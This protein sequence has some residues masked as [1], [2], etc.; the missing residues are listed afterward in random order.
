M[1][2]TEDVF[3]SFLLCPTKA[4]LLSQGQ[5]GTKSEYETYFTGVDKEYC[6][7]A[8]QGH[9][10]VD[11][12]LE[13]IGGN[14]GEREGALC[15]TTL[16]CG[17]MTAVRVI[18][19]VKG[20]SALGSFHYV[21][22]M[23]SANRSISKEERM[24]L[25]YQGLVLEGVQSRR[26]E[27]GR[28]IH[29]DSFIKVR[30]GDQIEKARKAVVSIKKMEVNPPSLMLNRHCHI[31]EFVSSCRVKAIE[32]D[33]LSLLA[34]IPSKEIETQ[35]KKGIFTVT[36]YS[37]TFRPRKK[38][39][40]VYPYNLKA[41]ALREK[42]THLYGTPALPAAGVQIYL[43]VEGDPDRDF[44]YLIG[45]VIVENG[46][47]KRHSFWAD[48]E[49]EEGAACL[50]F[51]NCIRSYGDYKP[52][53]Y[54][55]Y[56][57][58]FQQKVKSYA[59]DP[60]D[61]LIIE[62]MIAN[63]VNVLSIVYKHVF[64]PTYSNGLKDIGTYLGFKWTSEDASGINSLVWRAQFEETKDDN[65]KRRLIEYNL[66][67]CLALKRVVQFVGQIIKDVVGGGLS[68]D[69]FIQADALK[70][71]SINRWGRVDFVIKD[72]KRINDCAY[73][74]YQREKVFIRTD[75]RLKKANKR[76]IKKCYHRINKKIFIK[77]LKK[78]P[79]CRGRMY[80]NADC[81][82]TVFD[83]KFT[84][85]GVHRVL[86]SYCT[87][88]M[89]CSR[90]TKTMAMPDE[91]KVINR[92]GH[93]LVSFVVYQ[94]VEWHMPYDRTERMLFDLFGFSTRSMG[95]RL[96][97]MGV[98]YYRSTSQ[99]ILKRIL[100]GKFIHIDETKINVGKVSGYVWVFSNMEDVYF[101]YTT[102]RE[103]DF[104][105]EML[106]DFKGVIISDF[107]GAYCYPEW[108]QQKCLVHLIRDLNDDMRSAP[109]DEEYKKITEDFTM[110]LRK[111]IDT[112]DKYGLKRRH[113]AKHKKEVS[114]FFLNMVRG[115]FHSELAQKYQ[116]R[117]LKNEN[118]LFTFLDYDGVPWNNNNAEHAIKHFAVYRGGIE[119]FGGQTKEE[120][121]KS[122][123][124]LLSIFQTC[125]YRGINFLKFLV[126][127]ETDIDRFS[128]SR[129][130]RCPEIKL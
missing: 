126:S 91:Y 18:E 25:A 78:C 84:G 38:F 79:F 29:G 122:H 57:T 32:K 94:S 30:I 86:T 81:A 20:G 95:K 73:F 110:L 66:D 51:V 47:E 72:M 127:K 96:K 27:F 7:N 129:S 1:N 130:R 14:S 54:G 103:D 65:L 52:Y 44:Y 87:S 41:L 118:T 106:A 37:Y 117:F 28:V 11:G 120:G 111:V 55:S 64:F 22:V 77:V 108:I 48:N 112:V 99:Q 75:K 21:P 63:A 85:S 97:E 40:K 102:T 8:L 42:K 4:Y 121:I 68:R 35:N 60:D 61:V 10:V 5:V 12:S 74:D 89:R 45:A 114:K 90:C 24:G 15:Q 109:F 123:L 53:H 92:Y 62:K 23:F 39:R 83:L 70:A 128:Q 107:Y 19:R 58:K 71:K 6:T 80:I 113:L 88:Q 46:I 13:E 56:E 67:D 116:K 50:A 69:D 76:R 43:D 33:D 34:G 82:R 101:L 9:K 49:V 105:R 17:G 100:N 104:L 59:H 31:C 98:E 119:R 125:R 115:N 93:G 3:S 26:P 2:I 124:V 16:A 36:Q